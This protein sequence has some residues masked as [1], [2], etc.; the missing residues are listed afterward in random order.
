[1]APTT[2]V[3]EIKLEDIDFE[4]VAECTDKHVVKRYIKLIE[5]DGS[6]FTD[7]LKACKDKLLEIAPKDYYLLYPVQA[8]Q[9]EVDDITNDL[10]NWEESVKETD[11]ALRSAKKGKIFE[12]ETI[13]I[14]PVR[15][16]E[17]VVA[18]ANLQRKEPERKNKSL[19]DEESSKDQYARDTNTMKDYYRSWDK[20][21]VDQLEEEMDAEERR[22]EEERKKHFQDLKE[23]QAEAQATSSVQVDNLPSKIPQVHRKHMADTEK[24][25]GNE[26]FYAKDYEE[27]EAYYSRSLHFLA[28]DPSTWANRALVRLK[29]DRAQAALEDCEH[30]LAINPRYMKALHRKGKALYELRRDEEAVKFFQL[31]LGESPG[32]TQIN[33]DLMTARRRL[34]AQQPDEPTKAPRVF[35]PP[36]RTDD[37]SSVVIE[38]IVE[39]P[40]ATGTGKASAS[41]A[42]KAGFTRVVIEEDSDSE[43]EGASPGAVAST[44]D[45]QSANRQ[46]S[47]TTG[48][49]PASRSGFH[50]VQ[51]EEVSDSEEE[52]AASV[53]KSSPS[54]KVASPAKASAPAAA[55]N[56]RKV[57]IQEVSDSED[58]KP[59]PAGSSAAKSPQNE[60]VSNTF[61]EMD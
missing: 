8:S 4:K 48:G 58:E 43:D 6:Y 28:D 16:Q 40:P 60:D 52:E 13:P 61:D 37:S 21:D 22:V 46:S 2:N 36:S 12:D 14:A 30:A 9:E 19:E 24:E 17:P 56:F 33:G 53:Q 3:N 15:G 41:A 34:R 18:R 55:Q 26:A 20:V 44:S 57:E 5:D 31:A 10:L 25:K 7:L 11:A 35:K 47:A 49:A 54:S 27:A 42:P 32:N 51:I 1:M 59:I 38:E 45:A 29:L 50:K 23:E 39:D